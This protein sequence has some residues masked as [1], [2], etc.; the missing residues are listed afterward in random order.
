MH[1]NA[2]TQALHIHTHTHILVRAFIS[3]AL[4]KQRAKEGKKK[5]KND[6]CKLKTKSRLFL[7]PVFARVFVDTPGTRKLC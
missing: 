4:G 5:V 1:A 6:A 3:N 2:Y 7:S